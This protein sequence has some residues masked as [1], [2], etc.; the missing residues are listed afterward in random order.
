MKSRTKTIIGWVLTVLIGG[1]LL[2]ASASGKFLGGADVQNMMD[3]FG[4]HGNNRYYIGVV[5]VVC[6]VLFIIPRTGILGTLLLASYMGGA[7]VTHLEH[8]EPFVFQIVFAA[9]IWI[10]AF[11]RFPELGKRILGKRLN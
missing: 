2:I 10:T 7:I 3:N 6:T 8:G 9:F 5:E 11:I 4:L 1:F